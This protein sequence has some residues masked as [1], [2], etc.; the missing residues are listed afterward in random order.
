MELKF[1]IVSIKQIESHF[2]LNPDFKS[3]RGQYVEINYDVN[4]SFEKKDKMVSVIVSILSDGKKQPFT[5]NIATLGLFRFNKLL[6]KRQLERVA[7]I[8]C[9][10][11]IFP[12]IRE[13]IADLTRRADIPTFH[14]DPVNFIAM[15]EER[16]KT[17]DK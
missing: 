9:A 14:L 4:V 8:N 13:S 7:Y 16:E 12:Y 6:T 2:A 17:L 1:K 5:F 3:K 11:I 15:Y 10:S